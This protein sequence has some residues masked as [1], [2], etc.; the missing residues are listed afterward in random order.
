MQL[1]MSAARPRERRSAAF[2]RGAR[3]SLFAG[4]PPS[5]ALAPAARAP[6]HVLQIV[7]AVVVGD[8][9][10]GLDPTQCTNEHPA[11]VGVA[12]RVGITRVVGVAGDIAAL[13][14]VNGHAGI[15]LIKISVAPP[16]ESERFL[17]ADPRT[18]ILGDFLTLLDWPDGKK[19]EPGKRAADAE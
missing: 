18:F 12:F 15:D 6:D 11:A 2:L 3:L 5:A 13:A 14:T 9:L 17:G 7:I 1:A 8:F 10:G 4:A 19:T 16:F